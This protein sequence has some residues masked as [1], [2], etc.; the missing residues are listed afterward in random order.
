M[1]PLSEHW[2]DH[3]NDE[4]LAS[5]WGGGVFTTWLSV[6]F[7]GGSPTFRPIKNPASTSP[8]GPHAMSYAA[9]WTMIWRPIKRQLSC[10]AARIS[11][12]F[13]YAWKTM[14]MGTYPVSSF[15]TPRSECQIRWW[16]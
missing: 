8:F 3:M 11:I 16:L 5:S 14:C 15:H 7:L 12:A 10:V 4:Y 13:D 6:P 2:P 1:R 9:A